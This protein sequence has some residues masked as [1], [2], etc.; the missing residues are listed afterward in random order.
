[1]SQTLTINPK[2]PEFDI[3]QKAAG[4]L[5]D[6]NVISYPTETF[7]GLGVDITNEKAIK[8]LYE[9]KRRDYS[10]PIAMLVADKAMI[11]DYIGPVNESVTN[12]IKAFWPGPLTILFP[13]G[14]KISKSL[15]TNTGKIGIRISSHPVATAIVREFGKPITTTSANLSGYPPSL[16]TRHV[17]K[18]FKDKIDLIIDGGESEPSRGSTVI[19][20]SEDTMAIIRDGAI[21]AE[22]VIKIFQQ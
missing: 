3:V 13:A 7:Y 4:F 10:L 19:D 15:T 1:M 22:K 11:E 14:P 2:D 16:T 6:G 8:K 12:L 21:P 9:L 20:V 18:Y 17:Q 5:R